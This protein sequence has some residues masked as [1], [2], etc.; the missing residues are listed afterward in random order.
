MIVRL[1]LVYQRPRDVQ[2][3]FHPVAEGLERFGE[4]HG[5]LRD[6]I[7]PGR[8]KAQR[9]IEVLSSDESRRRVVAELTRALL[10]LH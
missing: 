5:P 8:E 1:L 6:G 3:G 4:C 7:Q 2:H 9:L 10:E